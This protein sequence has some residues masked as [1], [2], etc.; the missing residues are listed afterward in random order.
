MALQKINNTKKL[1]AGDVIQFNIK[2]RFSFGKTLDS[3]LLAYKVYEL[4][5][6]NDFVVNSYGYT[7]SGLVVSCTITGTPNQQTAGIITPAVIISVVFGI[8]AIALSITTYKVV[9]AVETV[10]VTPAGQIAT[11]TIP[12]AIIA[13]AG[14]FVY[15]YF[16][17]K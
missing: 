14:V 8:A 1:N 3:Y 13:I 12:L 9:S 11:A 17:K 5:K 16:K 15:L 10:A 7:D 6:R 2:Q 4:E